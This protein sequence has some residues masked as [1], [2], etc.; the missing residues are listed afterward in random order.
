VFGQKTSQN[1]TSALD[2]VN[3]ARLVAYIRRQARKVSF[4]FLFEPNDS[5]TRA[6]LKSAI[7]G[8]LS[9][10][11]MGRGL[12]DYLT[13]CDTSNNTPDRIG[14]NE[15]YID[16]ALRPVITAEFIIIPITV[17]SQGASLTT[18]S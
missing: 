3:V 18:S 5:I 4:G 8:M 10:V 9:N 13:V 14:A 12:V 2:R 1:Y 11:M 16:V 6:N 17:K 7:D 15:L